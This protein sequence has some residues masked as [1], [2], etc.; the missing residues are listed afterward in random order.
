MILSVTFA[1]IASFFFHTHFYIYRQ[2]SC[3]PIVPFLVQNVSL[4]SVSHLFLHFGYLNAGTIEGTNQ[5]NNR[6]LR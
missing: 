2:A 6:P 3:W 1:I 4:T 5:P